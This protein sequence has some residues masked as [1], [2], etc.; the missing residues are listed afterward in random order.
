MI[1][2]YLDKI[3][4]WDIQTSDP[5]CHFKEI[6][7]FYIFPKTATTAVEGIEPS[8]QRKGQTFDHRVA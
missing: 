2:L 1:N 7:L 3:I 4:L 8:P 6:K 5:L